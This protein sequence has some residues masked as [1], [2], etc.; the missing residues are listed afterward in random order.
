MNPRV[1]ET[2]HPNR[3]AHI[4][5]AR[6]HTHHRPRMMICLQRTTPLPLGQNNER[7]KDLVELAKIEPPAP[8]RESFIPQPAHITRVGKPADRE[9]VLLCAFHE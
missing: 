7:I 3:R 8:E 1:Q 2:E 4:P 5:N 6:P 9:V